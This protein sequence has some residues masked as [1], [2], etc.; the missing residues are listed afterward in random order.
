MSD[1]KEVLIMEALVQEFYRFFCYM[2][3]FLSLTFP[4][5]F[6]EHHCDL[7]DNCAHLGGNVSCVQ[8][9]VCELCG[10]EYGEL[11]AHNYLPVGQIGPTDGNPG[12]VVYA[13][14]MCGMSYKEEIK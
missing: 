2:M 6:G 1:Y 11:K 5:L 9:A 7:C 3:T 13:C 8:L 14:D 10:E 12:Y 4:S